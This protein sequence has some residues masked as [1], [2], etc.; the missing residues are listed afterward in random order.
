MIFNLLQ[1]TVVAAVGV[2]L[3]CWRAVVRRR[4]A[5][6]WGSLLARLRPG[7]GARELGNQPLREEWVEATPEENWNR[8]QG[9]HGLW[10]MYQNSRVMLEMAHYAAQ[11]TTSIDRQVLATLRSDALQIRFLV[12]ITLIQYAFRQANERICATA[13]C[14]TSM[15]TEMAA[16]MTQLTQGSL[17]YMLPA[18]LYS[19]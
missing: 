12:L 4:N 13:Y 17:G 14:A 15:Y 18:L 9:P 10:A 3:Y 7:S 11:N 19:S 8:I 2:Y 1:V 5:Q 16:R 6:S